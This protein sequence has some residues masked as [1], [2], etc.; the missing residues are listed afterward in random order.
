MLRTQYT[1]PDSCG[2]GVTGNDWVEAG[3]AVK[4]PTLHKSAP[5]QRI[6]QSTMLVML[7]LKT[8]LL[9]ILGTTATDGVAVNPFSLLPSLYFLSLCVCWMSWVFTVITELLD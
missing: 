8:S 7:S 9:T 6:V 2:K 5:Q 1:Y 3:A 4:F